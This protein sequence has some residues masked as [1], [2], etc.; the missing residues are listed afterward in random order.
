MKQEDLIKKKLE[1]AEKRILELVNSRDLKKLSDTERYLIS[2]FYEE[3]SLNRLETARI[4]YNASKN[5]AK[6]GYKD[7]A[8]TVAASYYSMYYIMHA[9][10]AL[11]YKAKLR[12]GI[13]GVH[14][15]TEYIILYYLVRTKKLAQYLYEEYL[16]TFETTAQIQK[17]SIDDFHPKAYAYAEKYDKSRAARETFTYNITASI[18]E[19]HAKNAI[20][21]SEEFIN[22]IRQLML[23]K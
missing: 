11:K 18:E 1:T 15:I 21:A 6:K 17:L 2:R 7:Y 12:E 16:K 5:P 20:A 10:L 13:R 14:I 8:E 19:Y 9:Y 3:K 4:I 22:T 23:V